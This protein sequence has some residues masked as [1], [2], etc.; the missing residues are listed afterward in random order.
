M[1]T[2]TT[3]ANLKKVIGKMREANGRRKI[4]KRWEVLAHSEKYKKAAVEEGCSRTT[5]Q[6]VEELFDGIFLNLQAKNM[7]KSFNV[8]KRILRRI[9]EKRQGQLSHCKIG[10]SENRFTSHILHYCTSR[11]MN[12]IRSYQMC[13]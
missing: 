9:V 7:V 12:D 13:V 2:K 1:K 11:S 8:Q 6:M 10:R 4:A 5:L 3:R